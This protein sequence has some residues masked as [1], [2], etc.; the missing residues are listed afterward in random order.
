MKQLLIT[1]GICF[2]GSLILFDGFL[3][4]NLKQPNRYDQ[5]F[6]LTAATDRCNCRNERSLILTKINCQKIIKPSMDKRQAIMQAALEL[7]A[8]RGY[9]GT[10]VSLIAQRAGVGSGTIYRYF[11]DKDDLV[12]TLFRHWKKLMLENSVENINKNQTVRSIFRQLLLNITRFALDHHE[13]FIFLEAHHHFPYLDQASKTVVDKSNARVLEFIQ[14]GQ[15]QEFIKLA[16]PNLI[17]SAVY[18][19]IIEAMKNHW[20][21]VQPLTQ[22]LIL[23]VEEMAWQAVRR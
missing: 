12:N 19:I 15:T 21:G 20:N 3:I 11:K 6:N 23:E 2:N 10:P 1:L 13:V 7:F 8:H 18:G 17:K 14:F 16:P 9:Y 22:E 5:N 4:S